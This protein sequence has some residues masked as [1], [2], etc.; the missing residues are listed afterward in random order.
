VERFRIPDEY[1]GHLDANSVATV[2]HWINHGGDLSGFYYYLFSGDYL[3]AAC[4]ASGA[5]FTGFGAL[6]RFLKISA[7][8]GSYGSPEAVDAWR[9]LAALEARDAR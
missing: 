4:I 6:L 3:N 5:N 9:G 7:P 2:E 1:L 8:D